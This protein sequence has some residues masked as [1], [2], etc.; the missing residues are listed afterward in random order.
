MQEQ[1]LY[2][3]RYKSINME[4]ATASED[5]A[6]ASEDVATAADGHGNGNTTDVARVT[7]SGVLTTSRHMLKELQHG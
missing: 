3:R 2:A 7:K 5:V 4:I 6:T 1:Q